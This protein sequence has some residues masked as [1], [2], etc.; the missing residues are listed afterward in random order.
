MA[1]EGH[2]RAAV[3]KLL[4]EQGP[5]TATEIGAE[6]GLSAAGVRRHLDVLIDAG[7]ARSTRS[8]AWQQKGRGRPAK[9]FQLTAATRDLGDRG[10]T[11]DLPELTHRGAREVVVG[12]PES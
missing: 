6:L 3:V 8:A 10:L 7:E 12:V 5:I 11:A 1:P 4:L 9:Q 2:T